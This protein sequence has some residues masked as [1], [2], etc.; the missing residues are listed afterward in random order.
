MK[1]QN[2]KIICITVLL[3]LSFIVSGCQS[4]SQMVDQQ[5]IN[6]GY[7]QLRI[8]LP[9]F[10]AQE[11][12]IFKKNG[13]DVELAMFD[14][15]QPLMD[16]LC[17][18]HIDIAGYTAFPI[19]YNAQ[20]RSKKQLYYATAIIE[21]DKHP[22]S[23]IM[24]K[25]DSP[26]KDIKDLSGKRI[27]I[28]PTIAYKTWIELILKE[29]GIDPGDVIVQQITPAMTPSALASGTVDAMFTTD[30]AVTTT[31][32]K[33]IGRLLYEGAIVPQYLWSP[34]P[35]GSFNMSKEF[36]DKNPDIA[37]QVVKS[38]DEAIDFIN[39]NPGEAKKI[40][41]KFLPESERPYVEYYPEARFLKSSEVSSTDLIKLA[42]AYLKLSI[43]KEPLDLTNMVYKY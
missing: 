40:M 22:I 43:I 18:G 9:V 32:Q 37:R 42:D 31:L 30:P 39:A 13:L 4:S 41:G 7:S 26:I 2:F 24:V 35:F 3:V 29:N 28:L 38:L 34:F 1:K 19:T 23:M 11:K 33:G 14:T 17:A 8:S 5:K 16:A 10:V 21:D 36:A 15:A 6:I 25:K 27:G 12:G 20:I